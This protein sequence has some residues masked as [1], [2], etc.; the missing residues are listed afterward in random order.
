MD[1]QEESNA[2]VSHEM[3]QLERKGRAWT[4]EQR[5]YILETMLAHM[6]DGGSAQDIC[7]EL[8]VSMATCWQWI[9][10]DEL[11]EK[12]YEEAKICRARCLIEGILHDLHATTT[13]EEARVVD[14]KARHMLRVAAMLNPREFSEKF[15]IESK[16]APTSAKAVTFVL[17]MPQPAEED[18][19]ELPVIPQP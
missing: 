17:N 7:D 8:G 12:R 1:K 5:E 4:P 14:V 15:A 10:S 3:R 2:L 9:K 13:M 19:G 6:E 16:R 18:K 11:L